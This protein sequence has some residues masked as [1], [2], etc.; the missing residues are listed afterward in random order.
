MIVTNASHRIEQRPPMYGNIIPTRQTVATNTRSSKVIEE[1]VDVETEDTQDLAMAT[2]EE[3]E[4]EEMS[5]EDARLLTQRAVKL[6]ETIGKN[7][8]DIGV[9]IY[10]V[11]K[12]NGHRAMGYESIKEYVADN[13]PLRAARTLARM[14]LRAEVTDQ[15]GLPFKSGVQL[16]VAEALGHIAIEDRR[17]VFRKASEMARDASAAAQTQYA[18]ERKEAAETGE[19]LEK[20]A[21]GIQKPTITAPFVEKAIKELAVSKISS[22]KRQGPKPAALATHVVDQ[23]SEVNVLDGVVYFKGFYKGKSIELYSS[24]AQVKAAINKVG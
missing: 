2:P 1:Q 15:V 9:I 7:E 18:K 22:E 12:G 10:Q 6:E 20:P 24:V 5:L 14:K 19:V 21:H 17:Q 8:Y 3:L 11:Q 23:A 13:F 4:V 16:S